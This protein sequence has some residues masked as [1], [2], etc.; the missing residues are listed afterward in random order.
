MPPRKV[1]TKMTKARDVADGVDTSS[2]LNSSSTL[3]PARLDSTG[4]I[5]SAL[6]D[7]V[8]GGK[9]LQVVEHTNGSSGNTNTQ[10]YND[11]ISG[12]ITTTASN[13]KILVIVRC[14]ANGNVD[15]DSQTNTIARCRILRN[16]QGS[17]AIVTSDSVVYDRGGLSRHSDSGLQKLDTPSAA[18]GASVTYKFQLDFVSGRPLEYNQDGLASIILME[19]AA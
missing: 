10:G 16:H 19:I 7:D 17:T 4:T 18:S 1:V 6:L 2:F 15:N 5:P 3:N 8:G 13:S 12:A 14:Q 9:V 11:I